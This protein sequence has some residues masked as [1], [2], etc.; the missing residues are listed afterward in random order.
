MLLCQ[1]AT[2][3]DYESTSITYLSL[4]PFLLIDKIMPL[5]EAGAKAEANIIVTSLRRCESDCEIALTRNYKKGKSDIDWDLLMDLYCSLINDYDDLIMCLSLPCVS[6]EVRTLYNG[7]PD[8]LWRGIKLVLEFMRYYQLD[9]RDYLAVF[10]RTTYTALAAF[11]EY[12]TK[13]QHIWMGYL[14][15]LCMY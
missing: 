4:F 7:I 1:P 14:G 15:R 8:W 10:F 6:S 5:S 2:I 3:I 12:E 13:D 11:S 9:T